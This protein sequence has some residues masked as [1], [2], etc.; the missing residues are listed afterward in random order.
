MLSRR[1]FL[2]L[3]ALGAAA[4]FLA[5]CGAR[6]AA[7]E[8]ALFARTATP[9]NTAT[10]TSTPTS[11]P[12]P[13]STA[14][15][16]ATATPTPTPT[17]TPSP[18]EAPTET[19]TS[20]PTATPTET[21]TPGPLRAISLI[22][23]PSRALVV[24]HVL[25]ALGIVSTQVRVDLGET[26][27]DLRTYDA[28]IFAGGEYRPE[29]FEHPIFQAERERIMEAL[30]ARVPILG[31]CLGN[32]LLAYWL[33]GEVVTGSWEIGW[34]PITVNEDG[35]ADPLLAGLGE[36]FYGFLWHGDQI[37]RL[38]EG[39]VLLASSEKCRVQAFRLGDLPVWGVQFNPQYDP[40]IAEGVIRAAK[41]LPKYGY[42]LDEMVATGYREYNDVAGKIFR[43]FFEV[44][45]KGQ[46]GHE[47]PAVSATATPGADGSHQDSP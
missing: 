2:R 42:N 19:P 46:E 8:F 18:T 9:T 24:D 11:T 7:G 10:P 40:V 37:K 27:P 22:H 6:S 30:E 5:A 36:S 3:A 13:T 29:E 38:P 17:A 43:N 12:S 41:S 15:A 47:A 32:Q 33:G 35:L 39:A 45:R 20:T 31:I 25:Q 26:V 28:V 14:T 44:V 21:P 23:G 16:T 4:E 34:L 1:A